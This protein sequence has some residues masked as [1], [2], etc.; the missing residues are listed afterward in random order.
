MLTHHLYN[1]ENV[2]IYVGDLFKKKTYNKS[3]SVRNICFLIHGI[4]QT[5][6]TVLA[7]KYITIQNK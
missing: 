6:N 3:C 5:D 4:I 1:I 7:G 2:L